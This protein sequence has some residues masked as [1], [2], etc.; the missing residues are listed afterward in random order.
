MSAAPR[1][2]RLTVVIPT[3]GRPLLLRTLRSLIAAKG[4]EDLEVIVSGRVPPGPVADEL[5]QLCEQ[6][7][8]LRHLSVQFERGDSSLKKNAGAV[9]A[10]A[11]FVGFLDDDV[12]V[13]REWPIRILEPFADPRVGLVSG[14]GLV[15][16]DLNRVGR[17]AGLALSSRAAGY[18]MARYRQDFV[19][20]VDCRWSQIIGCNAVYRRTTFEQIGRFD[21]AF[22]PGEEMIAA[23]RAQC[24]GWRLRF[25]PS[26]YV[27]HYP[28]QSL[29]RFW[30]QIWTYGA[31][32]IRL[33]RGGVEWEWSPLAPGAWVASLVV[34][35]FGS[36][37]WSLAMWLLLA[38][39]VAYGLLTLLFSFQILRETRDWRDAGVLLFIPIM[40]LSYGLGQWAEIFRPNRDFSESL[41]SS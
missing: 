36:L 38:E 11:E 14:P 34:L 16:R 9:E 39:C 22:Y 6:W 31:T 26:A 2:P 41:R 40:H 12:I 15:P 3:I 24:A 13:S 17:W 21:P 35:A 19:G 28:R 7:S 37:F 18:V 30:R 8:N 29:R 5:Q 23:Y 4:F 10:R 20:S 27:Y 32:R 33:L 1:Q 25:V